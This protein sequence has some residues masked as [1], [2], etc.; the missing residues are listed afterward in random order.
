M[1]LS[2]LLTV[3][4]LVTAAFLNS[5]GG[6]TDS[7]AKTS[8][9]KG[10]TGKGGL[11]GLGGTES[12][13]SSGD[14]GGGIPSGGSGGTPSGGSAGTPAAGGSAGSALGGAAGAVPSDP[15]SVP[16][17]ATT[18]A[19]PDSYCCDPS[20]RGGEPSCL[21]S[22]D[23]DCQGFRQ[24]CN[25]AADCPSGNLCCSVPAQAPWYVYSSSCEPA[26]DSMLPQICKTDAECANG[27]ACV[28]QICHGELVQ[29]C[30]AIADPEKRCQ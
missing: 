20:M 18:C 24:R 25:E 27:Q 28:S 29:T 21:P 17:G 26:C 30:G 22:D 23:F 8:G 6:E 11:G 12:G 5:C 9:G 1:R 10:G 15:G 16:C 13:G 14:G 3:I 2:G 7:D 4:G 19:L